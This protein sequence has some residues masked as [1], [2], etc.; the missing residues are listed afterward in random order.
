MNQFILNIMKVYCIASV[1][2][3]IYALYLKIKKSEN[4]DDIL[5]DNKDFEEK[6]NKIKKNRIMVFIIGIVIGLCFIIINE[7]SSISISSVAVSTKSIVEDISD[8]SVI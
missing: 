6:Y 4:L 2:Y 3:I 7:P 8:I 1:V 5:K